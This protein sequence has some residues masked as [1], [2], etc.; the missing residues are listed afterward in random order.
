M[1]EAGALE[2]LRGQGEA[3]ARSARLGALAGPEALWIAHPVAMRAPEGPSSSE[4]A[5]AD[6]RS[7]DSRGR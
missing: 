2:R 7:R 3:K 5:Q 6:A 4:C 1:S